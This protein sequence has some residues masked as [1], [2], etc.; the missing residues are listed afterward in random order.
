MLCNS[1]E[2]RDSM[3]YVLGGSPEW[4]TVPKLDTAST[5]TFALVFSMELGEHGRFDFSMGITHESSEEELFSERVGIRTEERS[6]I[7]QAGSPL[8]CPLVAHA[9]VTFTHP[10]GHR[11]FV[12]DPSGVEIGSMRFG[13]R[14]RG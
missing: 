1:A 7:E 4:W 11:F 12:L 3:L 2:V 5:L 8:Y 10:G 6:E 9:R 13:V 14:V